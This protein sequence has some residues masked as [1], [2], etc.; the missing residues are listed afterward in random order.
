MLQRQ[1]QRFYV[2][3]KILLLLLLISLIKFS[4]AQEKI[5]SGTIRSF[6]TGELLIGAQL[7][8]TES[9]DI[10]KTNAYGFFTLSIS[11]NKDTIPL[12]VE[13]DGYQ[14]D[15]LFLWLGDRQ[16][17]Y[18]I[19]LKEKTNEL[20]SVS[21]KTKR[22][23]KDIWGVGKISTSE[24]KNVPVI[25]GEKDILKTLQ[26][27]PGIKSAGDGNSGFYVR[28]GGADQ[29]LILLD[30]APIYNAT[31]LLGF[32]STFNSD[33]IKDVSIYKGNMPA[34]YGGRLSS[35]LDVHTDDGNMS[36]TELSGGIGIIS[37]RLNIEGPIVKDK[38]AYSIH[39]RST[40]ADLFLKLSKDSSVNQ[41]K[42]NFYD[43]NA[44]ANYQLGDNNR[45][46]LSAYRGRDNLGFGSNFGLNWGNSV[47]SLRWNHIY[48][49]DLF[50]NTSFQYSLYDYI[51]L[52][53]S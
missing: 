8:T 40:Y 48:K 10:A 47:W 43:L 36:T 37:S 51:V 19:K 49:N 21:V 6:N 44:K 45:L 50:S 34:Q 52:I 20:E 12:V 32:F 46:Y 15:T 42:L 23:E 24:I 28:G 14:T 41:N 9:E 35:V 16:T 11:S 27:L 18:T 31:H 29:N 7:R 26:L 30:E 2:N 25:F 53:E 39:A 13:M 17:N 38:G 22:K 4:Y 33:A 3:K 1:S 5:I